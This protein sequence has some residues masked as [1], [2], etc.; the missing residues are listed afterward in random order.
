MSLLKAIELRVSTRSYDKRL[1]ESEHLQ[2]LLTLSQSAVRL[3]DTPLRVELISGADRTQRILTYMIGSYGL[4]LTPPHVLVG[5]IPP[6]DI[7]A[8][9]DLG[10]VL[11]QMVVEAS[12]LELGTCWITGS[13]DAERAG[14]AVELEAGEVAA[15]IIALGYP[16][17]RGWGRLHTGA[18]RRLAGGHKRKPLKDIVFSDRWA[19][20]WSADDADPILTSILDLARL[21]PS[22]VNRQPWRFI[23]RSHD[24]VL[25]LTQPKPIDAG[26]VMAH[27]ALGAEVLGRKGRWEMIWG[28]DT[29]AQAC[30]LPYGVI[31]VGRFC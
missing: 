16:S 25:A 9:L 23:V 26:I 29:L 15:A 7:A 8:R 30:G 1:V 3:V 20:P 6:H 5:V 19:E 24:I 13:Y 11:E 10:F 22:G 18:I 2:R 21:A 4:V 17:Q 12:R 14:K 31:P 27:V 28:D